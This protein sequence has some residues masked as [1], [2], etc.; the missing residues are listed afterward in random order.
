MQPRRVPHRFL[1]AVTGLIIGAGVL[2]SSTLIWDGVTYA[3]VA[4][5][6]V[7]GVNGGAIIQ[8]A[9][10]SGATA[11]D[12]A[13]G[14]TA[15]RTLTVT[16]PETFAVSYSMTDS[17]SG[18]LFSGSTPAT[19]SFSGGVGELP[20]KGSTSVSVAVDLPLDAGNGYQGLQ[21]QVVVNVA[22]TQLVTNHTFSPPPSGPN[23]GPSGSGTFLVGNTQQVT[24]LIGNS[25]FRRTVQIEA[26]FGSPYWRQAERDLG[27]CLSMPSTPVAGGVSV[28]VTPAQIQSVRQARL[29]CVSLAMGRLG[30]V[31][32]P[33]SDLDI[34]TLAHLN[35]ALDG[36]SGNSLIVFDVTLHK[37]QLHLPTRGNGTWTQAGPGITY[38]LYVHPATQGVIPIRHLPAPG[39]ATVLFQQKLVHNTT[40]V[41]LW[42]LASDGV[43]VYVPSDQSI[44]SGLVTMSLTHLGTYYPLEYRVPFVDTLH[45]WGRED[46]AVAAAHLLASGMG[47]DHF[48]PNAKVTRAQFAAL[49][50]RTLDLSTRQGASS[51]QDVPTSAWYEPSV[52]AVSRAGLMGAVKGRE[53]KPGADISRESMATII[54]RILGVWHEGLKQ[55]V[56]ARAVLSRYKDGNKVPGWARQSMAIAVEHGI[57]KGIATEYLDPTALTTRAQTMAMLVHL[58]GV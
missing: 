42:Q 49:L 37:V 56:T 36:V 18:P 20:A 44:S 48:D 24:G 53:F 52:Q 47:G 34:S 17:V 25:K 4:T 19:V 46:V 5:F 45:S 1:T 32:L 38:G 31:T 41:S 15:V 13:P 54:A 29:D 35:P 9:S 26:E 8:N 14:D 28:S 16:N 11:T 57:L 50:V 12:M 39:Q 30:L 55:G 2:L 23:T 33:L 10:L 40:L 21:G 27:P 22:L 7:Q 51:F 3:H 43:P 58:F 6:Q